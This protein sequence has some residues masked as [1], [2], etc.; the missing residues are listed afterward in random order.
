[1]DQRVAPL[2]SEVRAQLE[3]LQ[4]SPKF[5]GSVRLLAFLRFIVEETLNG[6]GRSL[7]EAVIGNAVFGRG[8]LTTRR[9]TPRCGWRPRACVAS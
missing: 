3:R 6:G 8:R 5:A 9:S 7:K 2:P 1:M 4:G